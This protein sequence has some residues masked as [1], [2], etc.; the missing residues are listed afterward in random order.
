MIKDLEMWKDKAIKRPD[1]DDLWTKISSVGPLFYI[2]YKEW[3]NGYNLKMI[4]KFLP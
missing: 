3:K 1:T 2:C 4:F